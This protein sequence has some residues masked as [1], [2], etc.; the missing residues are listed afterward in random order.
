MLRVQ[1]SQ[2]PVFNAKLEST[3]SSVTDEAREYH[4]TVG[5]SIPGPILDDGNRID[6]HDDCVQY[7]KLRH[8]V[9]WSDV[10]LVCTTMG[11]LNSLP[12][13]IS[14]YDTCRLQPKNMESTLI[15][16]QRKRS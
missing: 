6:A 3:G 1:A 12:F 10:V 4:V 7:H 2:T 11:L 15:V 16:A 9:L 13:R 8:D 5:Q 14:V